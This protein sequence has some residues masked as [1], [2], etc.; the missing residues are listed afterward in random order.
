MSNRDDKPTYEEYCAIMESEHG[1]KAH[2]Q[3]QKSP[4]G[5]TVRFQPEHLLC[6]ECW[7]WA[8]TA[9]IEAR[10]FGGG[11]ARVQGVEKDGTSHGMSIEIAQETMP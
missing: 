2:A 9:Y 4:Q 7:E 10:I 6:D 5:R 11:R 1:F 8:D 3:I